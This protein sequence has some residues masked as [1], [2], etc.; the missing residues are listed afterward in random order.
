M[1]GSKCYVD[2]LY[3]SITLIGLEDSVRLVIDLRGLFL[4]SYTE[5]V[6]LKNSV[7][8]LNCFEKIR[9]WRTHTMSFGFAALV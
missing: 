1:G 6:C 7:R 5:Y 8:S 3:H 9:I 4:K 2:I